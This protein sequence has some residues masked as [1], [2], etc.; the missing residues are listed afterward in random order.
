VLAPKLNREASTKHTLI[1]LVLALNPC[2]PA[3]S[4]TR[5][6]RATTL[7]PIPQVWLPTAK[8]VTAPLRDGNAGTAWL[9]DFDP[10]M[11]LNESA[12]IVMA[13]GKAEQFGF[14][15]TVAPFNPKALA[16]M[17]PSAR[18]RSL[19]AQN[20]AKQPAPNPTR[21]LEQH[22]VKEQ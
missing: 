12:V 11:T 16:G 22:R 20:Y 1:W 10:V 14:A 17:Q 19:A 4:L 18:P 2:R 9:R 7:P 6:T 8:G 13:H 5:L 15:K 3:D 21:H